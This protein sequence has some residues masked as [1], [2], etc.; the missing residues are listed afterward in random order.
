MNASIDHPMVNE[1]LRLGES[2]QELDEFRERWEPLFAEAGLD[3]I[4][5]SLVEWAGRT[6]LDDPDQRR[7]LEEITRHLIF[8]FGI[9]L[10]QHTG[11]PQ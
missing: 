5:A 10:L 8:V 3:W 6:N 9:S 4:T 11:T 1:A 7:Q 2:T